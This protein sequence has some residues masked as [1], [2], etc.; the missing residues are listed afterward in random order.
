M[1]F[2]MMFSGKQHDPFPVSQWMKERKRWIEQKVRH[3]HI[4]HD[5]FLKNVYESGNNPFLLPLICGLPV[6]YMESFHSHPVE[7]QFYIWSDCFQKLEAGKRFSVKYIVYKVEQ[8][9]KQRDLLLRHLPLHEERNWEKSISSYLQLLAK[10]SYVRPQEE[11]LF[12]KI[13]EMARLNGMENPNHEVMLQQSIAG[14]LG[15]IK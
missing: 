12:I 13:K 2:P 3:G 4:V 8:R 11:G 14:F 10:L 15:T 1:R 6:K 5:R 7:W 9:L